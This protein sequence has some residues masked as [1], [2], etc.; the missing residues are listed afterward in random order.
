MDRAAAAAAANPL[1]L[2]Y[3]PALPRIGLLYLVESMGSVGGN[4]MQVG[5]F[6]YTNRRFGWGLRE[7]LPLAAF[8]GVVYIAGALAA[9]GLAARLG[10]RR[11]LA[12]F[13]ALA[14]AAACAALA[15]GSAQAGVVAAVLAYTATMAVTWPVL[16]AL[17][18]VGVDAHAM[19]RRVS[20]YNVIWAAV[21][22]VVL[23][24]NGA[25]IDFWP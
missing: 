21:G 5:I 22:A 1:P 23:A 9:Q 25:I 20:V 4:L 14:A 24:A 11:V 18:V 6:F 16:E 19:A 15:A 2:A 3:A 7:D 10:P 17:V 12:L 8:Q 13:Y